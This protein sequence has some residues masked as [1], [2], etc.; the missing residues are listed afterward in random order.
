MADW[1]HGPDSGSQAESE[2]EDLDP[3]DMEKFGDSDNE[4]E[5]GRRGGRKPGANREMEFVT[6]A[7]T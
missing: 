3:Y 1:A 4:G 6:S 7:L 5:R 2:E